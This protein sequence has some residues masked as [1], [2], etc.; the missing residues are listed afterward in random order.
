MVPMKLKKDRIENQCSLVHSE[1]VVS[2][3]NKGMEGMNSQQQLRNTII[4]LENIRID[5]HHVTV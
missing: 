4:E 1:R 2:I 3:S 5:R